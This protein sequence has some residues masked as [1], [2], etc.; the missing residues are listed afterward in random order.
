MI[1]RGKGSRAQ[2]TEFL[3]KS[4]CSKLIF[5]SVCLDENSQTCNV[6][7]SGQ[8]CNQN[9]CECLK[10][11]KNSIC[12]HCIDGYFPINGNNSIVDV[13]GRGVECK[14]ISDGNDKSNKL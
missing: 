5:Y 12:D 10:G 7:G 13:F 11:Y 14:G 3:Q 1:K 4:N 6:Y 9:S 8:S 2:V